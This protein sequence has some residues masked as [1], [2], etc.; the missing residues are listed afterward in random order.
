MLKRVLPYKNQQISGTLGGPIVKNKL[1]FFGNYE[2]ERQPLTSIWTTPYPRFNV[3]LDGIRNVKLGGVRL[4]QQLS[5]TMRLMGKVAHSGLFEPFGAGT[6]NHPSA[7]NSNREHNTDVI[8]QFTQVISARA[9]NEFRYA[10]SVA[11]SV[12][13]SPVRISAILP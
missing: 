13:P 10:G 2:Y 12:F 9:V 6:G 5:S 1:H 8:G 7:T 3:E 4:D 11:T